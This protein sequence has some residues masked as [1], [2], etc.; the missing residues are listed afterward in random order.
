MQFNLSLLLSGKMT[1][2]PSFLR[3]ERKN[4]ENR[5]M[6]GTG[7][8]LSQAKQIRK[9]NNAILEWWNGLDLKII[10]RVRNL[11]AKATVIIKSSS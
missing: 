2:R 4:L 11:H 8:L 9:V 10:E 3:T 7:Y 6:T 5:V 1:W